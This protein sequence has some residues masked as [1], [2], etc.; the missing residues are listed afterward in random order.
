MYNH[1]CTSSLIPFFLLFQSNVVASLLIC[2]LSRQGY[3]GLTANAFCTA[4]LN[5]FRSFSNVQQLAK[6]TTVNSLI[7]RQLPTQDCAISRNASL[8]QGCLVSW[9]CMDFHIRCIKLNCQ[10]LQ[11][12]APESYL[13]Q[14]LW[15]GRQKTNH[16]VKRSSNHIRSITC[17]LVIK[18][19]YVSCWL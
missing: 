9:T 15:I 10:K 13:W 12:Q 1:L 11:R 19:K 2:F 4:N 16:D 8:F 6:K 18:Q 3:Y 14:T 17:T 7:L 5:S